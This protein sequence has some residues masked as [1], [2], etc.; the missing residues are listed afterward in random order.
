MGNDPV[1][2]RILERWAEFYAD[3]RRPTGNANVREAGGMLTEEER[4][5]LEERGRVLAH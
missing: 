3:L 4:E 2:S 5:T 1:A